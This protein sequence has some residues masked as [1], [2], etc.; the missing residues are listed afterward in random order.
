MV[1]LGAASAG[2]SETSES[3]RKSVVRIDDNQGRRKQSARAVIICCQFWLPFQGIF[4]SYYYPLSSF[5]FQL[6][7]QDKFVV[8]CSIVGQ[9]AVCE[10]GLSDSLIRVSC[11]FLG[12]KGTQISLK[13]LSIHLNNIA[14]LLKIRVMIHKSI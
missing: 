12:L 14:N 8:V 2:D 1:S 9:R 4:L 7:V 11:Q 13:N 5:K 6:K 3:V 10:S